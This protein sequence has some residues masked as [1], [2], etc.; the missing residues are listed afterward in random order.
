MRAEKVIAHIDGDQKQSLVNHLFN[1]AKVA[2]ENAKGLQQA[3]ILFL[4]GLFHDLGKASRKFQDKLLYHPN[5]HVDHS[6]AGAYYLFQKIDEE[7]SDEL[8]FQKMLFKEICAY[9]ISSH[10]GMYDIP[11]RG[12]NSADYNYSH[13]HRRMKEYITDNQSIYE[14]DVLDFVAYLDKCLSKKSD[15]NSLSQLIGKAFE[16]FLHILGKIDSILLATKSQ[17]K[18]EYIFYCGL[19]ERLYLSYLKNADILDTI[20]AYGIQLSPMEVNQK[21]QLKTLYLNQIENLY[22]KY[23]NPVSAINQVRTELAET[24]LIRGK[25]D[26]TGIYRLNLPT[27]AGKTKLSARYAFHQL[28]KEKERFIYI[29]PFLSVLEQN[30]LEIKKIIKGE[31]KLNIDDVEFGILEYHSNMVTETEDDEDDKTILYRSYLQDTWDTNVVHSTMVQFFQTLYKTKASCI[32]RFANLANAVIILDEVQ[33]LPASVTSL[34]NLALN[35]L[36]NVMNTTVILCTATQPKYDLESLRHRLYYGDA[37]GENIDL[38]KL[39]NNQMEVFKRTT[40][41]KISEILGKQESEFTNLDELAEFIIAN[42][43]K[44][45]L[46][47]LNTKSVVKK[48]YKELQSMLDGKSIYHLSTSMCPKHRL[49]IIQQIKDKLTSNEPVICVSTQL[50]EAGVDI[51]FQMVI[52]SYAGI[53]SLV[54]SAGRCN[55]EGKYDSGEVYLVNLP[56]K[57]E[58]LTL[59]PDLLK[60][61][62]TTVGLL[63]NLANPISLVDLNNQFFESYFREMNPT[64]FD[65]PLGMDQAT[66]YDLL[67]A[68]MDVRNLLYQSFKSASIRFNLIQNDTVGLIVYYQESKEFIQQLFGLVDTYEM[69][70]DIKIYLAIKKLLRKLQPYTINVYQN[71]ELISKASKYLNGSI[72]VLPENYYTQDQGAVV[73]DVVDIIL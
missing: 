64:D 48:L 32:R 42:S 30:S 10:H 52:R 51:D 39:T 65:Y 58:N 53:D 47:I 34:L 23:K 44:S 31:D 3:N 7:I 45:V 1:V 36:K 69:T 17:D 43:E 26:S 24:I 4:L 49:D 70:Y 46:V 15:Y 50:I 73:N 2:A 22:E 61:K 57:E 12:D 33:S 67:S 63:R 14:E 28:S 5:Q 56:K 6:T 55:R 21:N 54:Q 71:S 41:Y 11:F 72:L 8:M 25:N 35:F 9:V 37:Q 68:N 40:T 66:V 16:D 59:L 19:L 62:E 38:V 60:K 20:N 18:Q 13:L 27:G 29:T